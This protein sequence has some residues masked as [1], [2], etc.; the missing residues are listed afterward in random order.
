VKLTVGERFAILGVLPE[1]GDFLTLKVMRLLRESLSFDEE[2]MAH[3]GFEERD[4]RLYWDDDKAEE[5][6]DFEFGDRQNELIVTALKKLDS[7]KQLTDEHFS[8]FEKFVQ[9]K[10]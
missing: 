1:S 7:S 10:D 5:T 2:E 9:E 6:R 8:I 4:D 3:Y